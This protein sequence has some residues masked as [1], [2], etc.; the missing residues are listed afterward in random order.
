MM[1]KR[2]VSGCAHG[3][4]GGRVVGGWSGRFSLMD[5]VGVDGN[6]CNG[7]AALDLGE[8]LH[9][10]EKLAAG[11]GR[12]VRQWVAPESGHV[13]SCCLGPRLVPGRQEREVALKLRSREERV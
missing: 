10:A 11:C 2:G 7:W 1:V 8:G 12:M 5:G 3:L 13:G 9:A 4:E 6:D